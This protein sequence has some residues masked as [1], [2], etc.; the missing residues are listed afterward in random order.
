MS[1]RNEITQ[2]GEV[3]LPDK[4]LSQALVQI[5][6]DQQTTTARQFP[7][8]IS[9]IVGNIMTLATLD[10]ETAE[11]CIYALPR[12]G[13]PIKGPS[14][15]FAEIVFS[16]WGNCRVST[17]IAGVNRT[18]KYVEAESVF[19]DLET[20][21]RQ[22]AT[23]RR[24]ISGRSGRIFSDDMIIVT[25]NAA[26]SIARR[27][28]ILAGVPRPVWRKAYERCEQVVAGTIETL[29]VTV[30]KTMKAFAAFGLTPERVCQA[31]NVAGVNE[32]KL[33]H[34][35]VLRG[36]Y[37]ALRSGEATVEEMFPGITAQ[38]TEKPATA[39]P[40]A[41]Q[42]A[43]AAEAAPKSAEVKKS[44]PPPVPDDD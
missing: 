12:D 2:D 14:I 13:K 7:R 39:Q 43:T 21:A 22:D 37:S 17:R 16:Q 28:A 41:T 23:T 19:I 11:E 30:T 42:T 25:G 6:T 26:G 8:S 18:E 5:E 33:D 40:E 27:N 15:R 44:T 3:M 35:P 1:N 4:Q 10:E 9:K 24:R 32:I 29:G 20:N 34:I 38:A 31:I 36:M